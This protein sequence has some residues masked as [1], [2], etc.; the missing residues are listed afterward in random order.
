[1]NC[2]EM[3]DFLMAYLDEELPA[4]QRQSFDE[5]LAACPPCIAYIET[6]RES[7]EL[8]KAVC[9]PDDDPVPDD[10]PERLIQAILSARQR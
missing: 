2:R 5:H 10:V 4:E 7:I 1:M 6:Y 8:G 9:S 3:T